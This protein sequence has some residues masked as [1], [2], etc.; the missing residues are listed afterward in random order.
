[1]TNPRH[2]LYVAAEAADAR[3]GAAALEDAGRSL[4]AAPAA[5]DEAVRERA[6]GAD[7]VVFAETPTTAAGSTLL[8]VLDACDGVPVV[9]FT[10]ATFAPTTAASTDG[11]AGYVRRDTQNATAH[12]ADQV[13][14]VCEGPASERSHDGDD[15]D[16]EPSASTDDV[17]VA[18]PPRAVT[19]SDGRTAGRALAVARALLDGECG[20]DP[21]A[22]VL[23]LAADQA[24]VRRCRLVR[25]GET[26]TETLASTV[27]PAA[28]VDPPRDAVVEAVRGEP[29][30]RDDGEGRP[31][32][33]VPVGENVV[34][35][36]TLDECSDRDGQ[37][38]E[39]REGGGADGPDVDGVVERLS[40]IATLFGAAIERRRTERE[41]RAERARLER[42]RDEVR[43]RLDEVADDRDALAALFR[44]LPD[45]A[46]RYTDEGERAVVADVTDAYESV[47]GCDRE[48]VRGRPVVELLS[49][50]EEDR[51]VVRD[52]IRAGERTT[53][54]RRR[55]TAEEVRE[56][57]LVVEPLTAGRSRP[58]WGRTG[59]AAWGDGFE[60]S[61]S[62][63]DRDG[64]LVY[65]DVTDRR[66]RERELAAA[67]SRLE[68]VGTL[69]DEEMRQ[70]LNVARGYL[71]LAEETGASD[72]FAEV[73]DAQEQL[74]EQLEQLDVLAGQD[75]VLVE[76]EP[77]AL[78]DAARRAWVT[79][80]TGDARLQLGRNAVIEADRARLQE[81]FEHLVRAAIG[82]DERAGGR[83]SA[84]GAAS[85]REGADQATS[86]EGQVGSDE[87]AS[88]TAHADDASAIG[89]VTDAAAGEP[90]TV[91]VG[92]TD[93]GFVVTG[94]ADLSLTETTPAEALDAQSVV[95]PTAAADGTG[96]RL[97]PVE[98]IADAHDWRVGV[99]TGGDGTA[100]AFRGVGT[101]D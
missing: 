78:H 80:E 16:E 34:L 97:G 62:A 63:G 79:V 25:V 46:I 92:A 98:R 44:R 60:W 51:A 17:V 66:R 26:A 56:F 1:M 6:P 49:G 65:R 101:D 30:V 87:P 43:R 27:E 54:D 61:Q 96:F 100:F 55:E 88:A 21:T 41:R 86:G 58:T 73:A 8:D 37:D 3:E 84:D 68:A 53:V 33:T 72:H 83:D 52:A 31:T 90:P 11:V 57:E 24:G 64:L 35:Q 81:L 70:P 12:L 40:T 9:L 45:P 39:S 23:E 74:R 22:S 10:E 91:T 28:I 48:A 93:D 13:R 47:F 19:E 36:A 94:R 85:D 69:V 42:A 4:A 32:V 7:C 99:A 5:D 71:E 76:P 38:V 82:D 67:T 59:D 75:G 2:V 95:G 15:A 29:S 20:P 77:I 18:E 89:S 50:P 14:W